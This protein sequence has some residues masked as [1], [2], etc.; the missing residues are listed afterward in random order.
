MKF[1]CYSPLCEYELLCDCDAPCCQGHSIHHLIVEYIDDNTLKFKPKTME[2]RYDREDVADL[3]IR[4][5][6]PSCGLSQMEV[7]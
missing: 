5:I 6:C 4:H 3:V 2:V 7:Y 1:T